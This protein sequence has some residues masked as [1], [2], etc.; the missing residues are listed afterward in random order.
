M[1]QLREPKSME[2]KGNIKTQELR[3]KP[4]FYLDKKSL[5]RYHLPQNKMKVLGICIYSVG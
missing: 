4:D 1:E 5:L 2:M 3:V